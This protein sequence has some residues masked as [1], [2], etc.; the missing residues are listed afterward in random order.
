MRS[1]VTRTA[2]PE[3]APRRCRSCGFENPQG[4]KFCHQCGAPFTGRCPR[5][6]KTSTSP[7]VTCHRP[8]R[9]RCCCHSDERRLP[10]QLPTSSAHPVAGESIN[11]GPWPAELLPAV[12][13]R[14]ART[15]VGCGGRGMACLGQMG[16]KGGEV[17]VAER[18]S[19]FRGE[20]IQRAGA[21]VVTG[22]ARSR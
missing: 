10:L 18:W 19:G 6:R 20:N 2:V 5:W 7:R 4:M 16:K 9:Q 17:S 11:V 21:A 13:Q 3:V 1:P 22:D 12:P 14:E 15:E 8:R